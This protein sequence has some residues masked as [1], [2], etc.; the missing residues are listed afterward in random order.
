MDDK[1]MVAFALLVLFGGN[2]S[3]I[4]NTVNPDI[5]SDPFTGDDG[6][7]LRAEI[8]RECEKNLSFLQLQ[9]DDIETT[10]T[11]LE[12]KYHAHSHKAPP[13]W[14]E[15]KLKLLQ[16]EINKTNQRVTDYNINAEGWKHRIVVLES[17]Q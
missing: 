5:R 9:I 11:D 4:L 6:E 10:D 12:E 8:R 16:T 14:V 15:Q 13:L 1:K 2:F 7:R 17:R 3:G